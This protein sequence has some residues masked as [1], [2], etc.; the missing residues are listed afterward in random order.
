MISSAGRHQHPEREA[1]QAATAAGEDGE[2]RSPATSAGEQ[3]AVTTPATSTLAQQARQGASSSPT[4]FSPPAAHGS[5][6]EG[7]PGPGWDSNQH[8]RLL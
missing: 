2:Q 3:E 1:E 5:P 8:W 6:E 7:V 4:S